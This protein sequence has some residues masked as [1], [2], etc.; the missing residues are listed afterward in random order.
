M[1]HS[2]SRPL[3]VFFAIA[4]PMVAVF[5]FSTT[6]GAEETPAETLGPIAAEITKTIDRALILSLGAAPQEIAIRQRTR[7]AAVEMFKDVRAMSAAYEKRVMESESIEDTEFF[8]LS[9]EA[10]ITSARATARDAVPDPM[11]SKQLARLTKLVD[12]LAAAYAAA[13]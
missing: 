11:V 8:F 3:Y 1:M 4:A 5:A 13:R 9:L 10:G 7:D 2:N 6:A 12:Q